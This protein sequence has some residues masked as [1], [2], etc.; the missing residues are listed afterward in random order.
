MMGTTR[1]QLAPMQLTPSKEPLLVT[2]YPH[3]TTCGYYSFGPLFYW[4]FSS[5]SPYPL[6]TGIS[7]E[8]LFNN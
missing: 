1:D 3:D 8:L 2:I 5:M 7:P 4:V 6:L